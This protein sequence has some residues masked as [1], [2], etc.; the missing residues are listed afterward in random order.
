M[1]SFF[2][3]LAGSRTRLGVDIG[4]AS[5]K[6]AE[7]YHG[8]NGPTLKNYGVLESLDYLERGNAAFQTSTLHADEQMIARNLRVLMRESGI[9]PGEAVASLPSFSAF[10]TLI[11]VPV[12]TDE[13][14]A[15]SMVL[16]AKQ[17]IPLP[18]TETTLDW[19]KVGERIDE[20]GNKKL[21]IFLVS[22]PNNAVQSV[23]KIFELAKLP[24]VGLEIE[25]AGLARS[26]TPDKKEPTLIVD[27]GS[28]STTLIVA[29]A[30]LLRF[31]GQTDFAGGSLTQVLVNSLRLS[32]KRAE[33]IK[34]RRGL[35]G[36][37]GEQQLSTLLEPILDVIINE[38][39]RAK[40]NYETTY[41]SKVSSVV[42]SG[43]G[44]NLPGL[45][46]YAGEVIG[47]PCSK[48]QPLRSLKYPPEMDSFIGELGPLLSV[49]IG[50]AMKL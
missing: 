42:F 37:G 4:T 26:L 17:Y 29:Q 11:E 40:N 19:T 32:A 13:E 18:I 12:L 38:S 28:R 48:A 7:V 34:R 49:A 23:K 47:L 21:Q 10:T 41:K 6:I 14:L 35:T 33:E 25:G 39:I 22:I 20:D 27:I 46:N 1:S 5:I 24:L 43:G 31:V 44:A 2:K 30:G 16:H 36:M 9:E 15:G 50:L 45:M 8:D 3:K